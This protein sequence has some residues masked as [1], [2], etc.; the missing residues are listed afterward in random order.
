MK[1]CS[2]ICGAPC[3]TIQKEKVEGL[4]IAADKG[5]DY[6]LAQGITPDYAVGDFDSADSAVPNGIKTVTVPSEKDDTDTH[7]AVS[8]A[9]E[10]GCTQFRFF[11]AVG[12]RLD[13]TIANIQTLLELKR[14]NMNG[15]LY[16]D[17][18][19][20]CVAADET[21]TIPKND[22]YLS[23]FALSE[24]AEVSLRGVKY[25][26]DRHTLTNTFP[27][28]V[29]NEVTDE[30]AQVIVHSGDVLIISEKS[31]RKNTE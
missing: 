19:E 7:L 25:P 3:K 6:C 16:G 4:I 18:C 10:C 31:D 20:V 17:T 15:I 22:G 21:V 1:I 14:N 12:G 13:H 8:L 28:G 5:L 27:L 2:I 30:S 23:V 24:R 11:C 26:V 29:S 9:V